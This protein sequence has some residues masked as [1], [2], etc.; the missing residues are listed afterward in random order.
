MQKTWVQSLGLEDPWRREWLPTIFLPGEF[1]GQR[2]LAGYSPWGCK[3][4]D[5]TEQLT[6]H[7]SA[8]WCLSFLIHCIGLSFFPV[9]SIY[10]HSHLKGKHWHWRAASLPLSH[11][12]SPGSLVGYSAQGRKE[13]D[14]TVCTPKGKHSYGWVCPRPSSLPFSNV[15]TYILFLAGRL[16]TMGSQNWTWLSN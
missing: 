1:H 12:R 10:F 16:Q 11:Q 3:E 14:M 4:L 13:L 8:K 15:I 5:T 6:C 7:S 2:R 9:D